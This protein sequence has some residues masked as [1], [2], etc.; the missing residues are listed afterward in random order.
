MRTH[1]P[2]KK[3]DPSAASSSSASTRVGMWLRRLRAWLTFV[4]CF[5]RSLEGEWVARSRSE[6]TS[7]FT[8]L[9]LNKTFL[10]LLLLAVALGVLLVHC[11]SFE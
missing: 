7:H 2:S 5:S 9:A 3:Q 11:V 8:A 1:L 6:S 4:S 10:L